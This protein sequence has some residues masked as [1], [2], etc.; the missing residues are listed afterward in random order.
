VYDDLEV[1][2]LD[3]GELADRVRREKDPAA[4]A[5]LLVAEQSRLADALR[6]R[7]DAGE[8]IEELE[9]LLVKLADPKATSSELA[10]WIAR[11]LEIIDPPGRSR[12][13]FWR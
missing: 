2:D 1:L 5:R 7:G 9:A 11:A 8:R 12:A 13:A 6:A 3:L 10:Q 4:A